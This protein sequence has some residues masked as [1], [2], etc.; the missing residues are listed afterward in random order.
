MVEAGE[1]FS[2]V[3][4]CNDVMSYLWA[5]NTSSIMVRLGK[6]NRAL[7]CC[8]ALHSGTSRWNARMLQV[9]LSQWKHSWR[10]CCSYGTRLLLFDLGVYETLP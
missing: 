8:S 6:A 4:V 10:G 5:N 7:N 3:C 9:S 1:G 2:V